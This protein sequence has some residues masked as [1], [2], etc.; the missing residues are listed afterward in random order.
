MNRFGIEA[1]RGQRLLLLQGPVGPFF[2]RLTHDLRQAGATV[3]KVNF[4]GG[5][6]L[7]S[8]KGAFRFTGKMNDWPD[9]LATLLDTLRI[10][11]VLLFGDCRP[12]HQAAH[13]I[14]LKKGI[15]VGVFEEG[16]LRP[17][18]IT[19]EQ[20]GVNANS[21]APTSPGYYLNA[22]LP[23]PPE[24]KTVGKSFRFAALWAI[25]Y[26]LASVL[27]KPAFPHYQHHRPLC[28]TEGVHWIRS[29]WR[30]GY[31][32]IKER[33]E[34]RKLTTRL[35]KNFFLVPL[36][37]NTD[38][39]I[40][41]HSPFASVEEFI[42]YTV[43]SFARYATSKSHLV[44]KHHPMDRGYNDYTAVVNRLRAQYNLKGRLHYIHDQ[45]LPELLKHARG[46]VMVNSTVGLS[47]LQRGIPTK[48]CGKAM[49]D[50]DGLTFKGDLDDFWIEAHRF[51]MN[52]KLFRQFRKYLVWHT[53]LNGNFYRRL[54]LEGSRAGLVWT[55]PLS[56]LPSLPPPLTVD[57]PETAEK[58]SDKQE[59]TLSLKHA[60]GLA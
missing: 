27:L 9:Y 52:Q 12:I 60:Q 7:F 30:K 46:T 19:F 11:C 50:L 41:S 6:C 40:R 23:N 16:Y 3:Y 36:Q 44:I 18:Y 2:R 8:P 38:S 35:S 31:Y 22:K 37:V 26:Y 54:A 49:Y 42:L 4:N 48:L 25:L 43:D 17:D 45:P 53:Q 59:K 14:A 21:R 13:A 58:T 28:L 15:R 10:D 56:P 29:L 55:T 51:R 33:K 39:Q 24:T 32:A 57:P 1:F 34:I 20:Y 5:D 47:A